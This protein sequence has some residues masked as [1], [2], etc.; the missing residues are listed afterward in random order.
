M[1]KRKTQAKKMK[2]KSFAYFCVYKFTT[3][4]YGNVLLFNFIDFLHH[5]IHKI[6][7]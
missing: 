5:E 2:A 3:Q 7:Q 6:K 4:K 1:K